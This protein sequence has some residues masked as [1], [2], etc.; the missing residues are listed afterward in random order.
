M[1][2]YSLTKDVKMLSRSTLQTLAPL[3]GLE[4]NHV[5]LVLST[6]NSHCWSLLLVYDCE[7][8]SFV[9]IGT[10]SRER[11]KGEKLARNW[12]SFLWVSFKISHSWILSTTYLLQHGT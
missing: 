2:K 11:K 6:E 8:Y 1:G 12:F 4:P 10:G 7:A 5:V 9:W 3:A